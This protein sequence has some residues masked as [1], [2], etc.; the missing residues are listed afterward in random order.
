MRIDPSQFHIVNITDTCSIW[1]VLSSRVLYNAAITAN[2]VFSCTSYVLYECLHK[3]R[4]TARQEDEEL[5][6]RLQAE[7]GK[8]HFPEFPLAIED[9]QDP[10]VMDLRGRLGRGELS[11]IAFALRTGQA[12][13]TDDGKARKLAER[14][15]PLDKVQTTPKLFGWLLFTNHL[16]DADKDV[17]VDEHQRLRPQR[18]LTPHLDEMYRWA[19]ECRLKTQTCP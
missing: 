19:L 8:R 2:C 9:L 16:S 12:L 5:K 15:V 6:R 4:K 17:I 11:V 7:V 3:P 13:M 1:N 18:P 10:R 14:L